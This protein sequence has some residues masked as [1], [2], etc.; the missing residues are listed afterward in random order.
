MESSIREAIRKSRSSAA[1]VREVLLPHTKYGLPVYYLILFA[2]ASAN[3]AR[4]DGARFGL[5]VRRRT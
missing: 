5:S 2:E 3:L 1:E 4:F